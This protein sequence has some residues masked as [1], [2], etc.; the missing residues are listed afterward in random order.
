MLYNITLL[1]YNNFVNII[2]KENIMKKLFIMLVISVLL[3]IS[4]FAAENTVYVNDGGSGDGSSASAPVGTLAFVKV[5]CMGADLAD[6]S[7]E[8]MLLWGQ[9]VV[10]FLVACWVYR[11]R[12]NHTIFK[13]AK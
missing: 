11:K 10:Y 8:M 7:R 1:S 13:Q 12:M 6:I 9:C 4:A 5:N 2:C 3:L